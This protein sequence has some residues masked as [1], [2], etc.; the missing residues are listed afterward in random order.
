MGLLSVLFEEPLS[1]LNLLQSGRTI[2]K[3]KEIKHK[4]VAREEISLLLL[5]KSVLWR[6]GRKMSRIQAYFRH[7]HSSL[8]CRW[9]ALCIESPPQPSQTASRKYVIY[10]FSCQSNNNILTGLQLLVDFKMI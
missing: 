3:R 8:H 10:V 1:S 7:K 9:N 5:T 6:A 4:P 2:S